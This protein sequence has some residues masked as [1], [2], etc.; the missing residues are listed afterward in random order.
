MWRNTKAKVNVCEAWRRKKDNHQKTKTKRKKN[1]NEQKEI[2]DI[3]NKFNVCVI[4]KGFP[5]GTSDEEPACQCR[6]CKRRGFN[7]WVRKIPCRRECQPTLGSLPGE[8]HGQRSLAGY[9]PQGHKE[10]DTNEC[11]CVCMYTHTQANQTDQRTWFL[12]GEQRAVVPSCRYIPKT[13]YLCL[14]I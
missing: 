9:S 4:G 3:V 14:H 5:G 8:S 11:A 10:S 1:K 13:I 12:F 2:W 6:R 7:P